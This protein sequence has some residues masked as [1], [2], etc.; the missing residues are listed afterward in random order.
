MWQNV[1]DME[2]NNGRNCIIN[3]Q[4]TMHMGYER[5][6]EAMRMGGRGADSSENTHEVEVGGETSG[7]SIGLENGG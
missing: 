3:S 6:I 7:W 4:E 2:D 1:S 5:T